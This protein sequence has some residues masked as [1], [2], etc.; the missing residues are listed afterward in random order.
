MK[1]SIAILLTVL[2]L[3]FNL[4]VI[5]NLHLCD[6]TINS[7]SVVDKSHACCPQPASCCHDLAF[8]L[9][10]K[11]DYTGSDFVDFKV[12]KTFEYAV[13]NDVQA[14]LTYNE[15]QANPSLISEA[16]LVY[17]KTPIYLSN[18]ILLI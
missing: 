11:A 9:S 5:L 7:I 12:N 15:L 10:I 18:R 17:S 6:R 8:Q 3:L 14:T 4:G 16:A 2:Y 1:K 13:I